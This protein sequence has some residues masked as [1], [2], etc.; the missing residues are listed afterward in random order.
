MGPCP[1]LQADVMQE[2]VLEWSAGRESRKCCGEST[3]PIP[4]YSLSAPK[5]LG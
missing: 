3:A 5:T 2:G 1:S 4:K